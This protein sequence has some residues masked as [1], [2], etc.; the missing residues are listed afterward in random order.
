MPLFSVAMRFK[1]KGAKYI[2][3][4]LT[5]RDAGGLLEWLKW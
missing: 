2:V 1:M 4:C 3:W 5:G